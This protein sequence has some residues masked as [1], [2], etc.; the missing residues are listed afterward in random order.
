MSTYFEEK[1]QKTLV[2]SLFTIISAKVY[3][4]QPY[5]NMIYLK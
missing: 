4:L 3:T 2:V 5:Q 1:K